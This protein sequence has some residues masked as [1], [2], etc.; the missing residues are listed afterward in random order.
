MSSEEEVSRNL[1]MIEYYKEQLSALD[2]QAQYLQAAIADYYK[3]KMTVENLK[4][5]QKGAEILVPVGLGV[6][7]TAS[8]KDTSK[9][10]VDIGA[11]FVVEKNADNAMKKID[12]RI[13]SL[14]KNQEKLFTVAQQVQTDA[15]TLA[16]KTQQMIA[17]SK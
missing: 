9:I 15:Q 16:N 7:V 14:Q 8:T 3:A 2:M 12:S 1:S 10:L 6:F 5:Q 4:K 13:E 11:G 17:E